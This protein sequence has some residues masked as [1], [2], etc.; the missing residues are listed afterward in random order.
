MRK[1]LMLLIFVCSQ[2]ALAE[3]ISDSKKLLVDELLVQMGQSATDAGKV[4]S[5]MLY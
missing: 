5:D 3:N 1:L 4:F 2:S